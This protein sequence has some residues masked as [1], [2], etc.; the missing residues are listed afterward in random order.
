[1]TAITGTLPTLRATISSYFAMYV[2]NTGKCGL[3]YKLAPD[4]T[5]ALSR[6]K[7][8]KKVKYRI[9][10]PVSANAVGSDKLAPLFVENSLQ[11]QSYKEHSALDYVL[12]CRF[13]TCTWMKAEMFST[14]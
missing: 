1:M 13:I 14:G 6:P 9:S 2:H 12:D 5:V 11:M 3:F 7:G 8:Q 10:I 4:R